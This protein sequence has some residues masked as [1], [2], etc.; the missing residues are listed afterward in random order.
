MKFA[1][2][3]DLKLAN[4]FGP[5]KA[6]RRWTW[7]SPNGKH[8]N[9][10]DYIVI[11]R[12]FQTSVNIAKRSF[13][14]VDIGSDHDL[15]MMTFKLHLKKV[16]KQGH[17]RIRFDLEKLK[18]PEVAEAFKAMIGGKFAPL[19]LLDADDVSMDDLINKFNVAVTETANE[20]LGKYRHHKQ[21][22]VTPNILHLCNKR[23]ELKKDKF[24][25]EGAKQYKAVNQQ[26]KKGMVK[27]RET[28]IE[29]RCQEIDDSLG[30]NNNKKAYQLVKDLTSSKQGRTTTIQDKNGK[31]LTE[32]RDILNRW[33]EYCSELCNHKAKGD[34]EVLKHP[35]V[36]NIDSHL[37]LR[38]EVEAAVKSLKP[39]KSAGVDNIPAELLQAGGETMIDVLL[40]ICNKIWQTGEWPTP[41]TQSLVITLPK[42]G[43]LLQCQ[44]YRTIKLISHASKVILKILL[45]RLA[46]QVETIIAEEQAGFRPGRSTTEQ[47]FSLRILC[48][49]YL[50]H[51]QDLFHVFVDFK[52]AFDRVWHAALWST[53]KLYNIN[54]NLIKVIENLYS[55]ATSAVYYNGSVGE[56][57]RTT[58]GVRQGY[59]L[60]PTL[61][62]IFLK[63]IMTDALE[64]HEGSVSIGG[65]TITNLRFAD[66]IDALAGKEDE[67]V[68]LI[69]HLD[70]TSTKYHMEISVEKTKM[71]TNN[72]RGIS[73]D[74]RI[75]GQKLETVQSFKYLGSVVTDEGSKQ[76]I[77]SRI[78]QTIG[79]LTKLK[80]IWK[81]KNISS[82]IRLMQSSIIS[83]FLYACETWTI[84]AELEKKI[85]TTEMR[86]FRRLLGISYRDHVTNEK[87]GNRIRQV[88]GP[89]E[90]LLTTVKK[91]KLRWYGHKTRSTGLATMILQGTV[92]GGRRRGRQKKR[93]ED[94]TEW[95]GLKL[96]EALRKAEN[97]EEWRTVVARSSLV[98]QRSIRL[99][100]K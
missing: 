91:R 53:M 10:I 26:I 43:N 95:T 74:V 87:V 46:P 15:V 40:N 79:A 32:D 1:S 98:P 97:R 36:T 71:M 100:D 99:W 60:S 39:G 86:C 93:W 34:P 13:P 50:Q 6:S 82:K 7:H 77:M 27:A 14:G 63:R 44:N 24:T 31:R 88:I 37:I 33:T 25:T 96:G 5:H 64:N 49:R 84:T 92:Q 16:S 72:T 20:T 48:E 11:K 38:E 2:L 12:R 85:R 90:G 45:N 35:P 62:S 30:K 57:F 89:Y 29:E 75:G 94:V 69:N 19:T 3:N 56:W 47:I 9:Q 81:D 66:D 68:T 21:H 4:T 17:S 67:L 70:T 42:K 22:W 61:F 51:Q 76:E 78:A 58:V 65:R 18:D 83:I 80:T 23:R 52:K 54:A 55:K 41:W 73:L 59:L 8:H 28:W